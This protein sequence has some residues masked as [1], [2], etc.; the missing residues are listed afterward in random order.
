MP[1]KIFEKILFTKINDYIK[2]FSELQTD[3]WEK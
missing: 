2:P 1:K 3:F